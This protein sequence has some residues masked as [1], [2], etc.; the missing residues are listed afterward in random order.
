MSGYSNG[1]KLLL[2]IIFKGEPTGHNENISTQ[3]YRVEFMVAVTQETGLI[4]E[5]LFYSLE[6]FG[7]LTWLTMQNMFY[8]W[9][10]FHA[11]LRKLFQFTTFD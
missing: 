3:S 10:K 9:K 6:N 2:F 5:V 4:E 1:T 8:H 11:A 7:V